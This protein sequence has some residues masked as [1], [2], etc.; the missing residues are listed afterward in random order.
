MYSYV[1]FYI[2]FFRFYHNFSRSQIAQLLSKWDNT[3]KNGCEWTR[4]SEDHNS[5]LMSFRPYVFCDQS[6]NSILNLAFWK[7][8]LMIFGRGRW[9]VRS[10][11]ICTTTCTKGQKGFYNFCLQKRVENNYYYLKKNSNI[12]MEKDRFNSI[13]LNWH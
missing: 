2:Y 8:D 6:N 12:N 4:V 3:A 5:G 9:Y 11:Y 7:F 13:K 1:Y 10:V